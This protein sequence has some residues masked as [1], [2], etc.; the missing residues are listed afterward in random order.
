[1]KNIW[2]EHPLF[3]CDVSGKPLTS[4]I[5]SIFGHNNIFKVFKNQPSYFKLEHYMKTR[6]LSL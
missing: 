3:S 2:S 4:E 5:K 6:G 1:M